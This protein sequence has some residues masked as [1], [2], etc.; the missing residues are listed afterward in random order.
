M[1]SN[2]I[3]GVG[4]IADFLFHRIEDLAVFNRTADVVVIG[5][6]RTVLVEMLHHPTNRLVRRLCSSA[7]AKL[8]EIECLC[9]RQELDPEDR[10][11]VPQNLFGFVR[12][13]LEFLI[14][15]FN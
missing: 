7:K 15:L 6:Q 11:S 3:P 13:G 1:N 12:V 4:E 8:T 10:A 2:G 5:E 9:S 14:A